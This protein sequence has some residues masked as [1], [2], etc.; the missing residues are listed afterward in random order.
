MLL[1]SELHEDL[2]TEERSQ[3]FYE[4]APALANS[5][6][7][8]NC[9]TTFHRNTS[10]VAKPTKVHEKVKFDPPSANLQGNQCA[11]LQID[12][13]I[14]R[15]VNWFLI[16]TQ[17]CKVQ[18]KSLLHEEYERACPSATNFRSTSAQYKIKSM[19]RDLLMVA[20]Q[21]IPNSEQAE[22]IDEFIKWA[23]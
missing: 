21:Q 1:L 11:S 18:P 8:F 2:L 10:Q 5:T 9:K 20:P 12:Q 6:T 13:E 17:H 23:C 3:G 4:P 22:V 14:A 15:I 7:L 19:Q 16:G